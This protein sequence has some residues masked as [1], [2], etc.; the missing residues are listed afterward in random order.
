MDD[1]VNVPPAVVALL[2]RSNIVLYPVLVRLVRV[3][4]GGPSLGATQALAAA[5]G[6]RAFADALDLTFAVRTAEEDAGTGYV[7]GYY[8]AEN[9][10]DGKYHT[11]TVKLHNK[12]PDKQTLEVR[13]RPGYVATK[14]ALATPSPTPGELFGGPVVSARIG[15]AAQATP[16]TQHPGLYDVRLTVDLHDIHV[17]RK[18]DHFTGTF[19]VSVPNP[20][21]KGTVN[22]GAVAV[23]LT[24]EQLAKGLENGFDVAMTGVPSESDEIRVVVRD[25]ATG[26]AG[27]LR[28]PVP[29]H[30]GIAASAK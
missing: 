8:P 2:Q 9:L 21:S 4:P 14:I 29:K 30:D 1:P 12:A 6:G 11:I 7:L 16:E 13:Y 18:D 17:D 20:S 26:I 19:D 15:L 22:T 25:R 24:D 5:T 10:L 23:N 28:I 27:S 3:E